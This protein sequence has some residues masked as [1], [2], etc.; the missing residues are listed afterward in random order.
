MSRCPGLVVGFALASILA[1]RAAVLAAPPPPDTRSVEAL[2][3][4][5]PDVEAIRALGP[6]VLPALAALYERSDAAGRTRIATTFYALGWMSEDAKRV[7]MRDVHTTDTNLRLQVQWA[8][9]RVSNDADVVETLVANMRNDDN[10]LFR[11]KAA[12]AL[13]NDQIHLTEDQKVRLYQRLVEALGDDKL[14]VR[15]IASKALQIQTGQTKNFDPAGTPQAR[16]AAIREWTRWLD[17]Y[18][19]HL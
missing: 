5:S 13:A 18:R 3:S 6:G 8:L 19:S 2:L 9:G 12:C 11:D 17:T 14:Q 16:E 15:Q 7:L 1:A 10:P 4:P